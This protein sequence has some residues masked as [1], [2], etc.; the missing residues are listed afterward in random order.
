MPRRIVVIGGGAAGTASAL[1]AR[2]TDRTAQITLINREKL[3]EYSRCGLPYVISKVIP[4]PENVIIQEASALKQMMRIDLRLHTEATD[5]D[6]KNKIVKA[7]SLDSGEKL[8]FPFDALILALGA[9]PGSA[10]VHGLEGKKN[11]FKLRTMHDVEEISKLAL[12]GKTAAILGASLIGMELA[13][14]LSH[15]KLKVIVIHRSP[16]TLSTLLDPDMSQLIRVEAEK[17]GVKFA[18]GTTVQEVIGSERVERIKTVRGRNV[19]S[20]PYGRGYWNTAGNWVGC[21]DRSKDWKERGDTRGR[22]YVC[23]CGRRLRGWGLCRIS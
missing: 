11:V 8:S 18:L 16:E 17:E 6:M 13:E 2:R 22:P 23:G 21:Q 20:R 3:P 14:A 4:K 10:P 1:E 19:P 5:I 9:K 12:P 15:L 7:E